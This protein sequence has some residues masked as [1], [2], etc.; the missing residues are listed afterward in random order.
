MRMW[1]YVP[2]LNDFK[3]VVLLNQQNQELLSTHQIK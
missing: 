1:K 2:N 3:M